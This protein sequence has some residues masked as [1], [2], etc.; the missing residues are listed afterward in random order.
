MSWEEEE[1]ATTTW[2]EGSCG[3]G[4]R[5]SDS[6]RWQGA[7]VCV[8]EGSGM[9]AASVVRDCKDPQRLT[10]W[11]PVHLCA[12]EEGMRPMSAN[13]VTTSERSRRSLHQGTL[14]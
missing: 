2:Q 12:E 9:L 4:N 3:A 14:G 8:Q 11:T 7:R 10:P 6:I 13:P 5:G 1:G